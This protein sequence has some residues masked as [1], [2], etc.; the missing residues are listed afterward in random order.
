MHK[1]DTVASG[2][3]LFFLSDSCM[4]VVSKFYH[5]FRN[6]SRLLLVVATALL[7]D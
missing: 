4:E 7:T 2:G 5:T 3:W 1:Q 6:V